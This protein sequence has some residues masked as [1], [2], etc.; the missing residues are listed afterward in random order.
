MIKK[1]IKAWL[2]YAGISWLMYGISVGVLESFETMIENKKAGN[3]L[4]LITKETT[5]EPAIVG[6]F[7]NFKKAFKLLEE[8]EE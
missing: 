5:V 2:A 8:N 3:G 4:K 1:F 7:K 6:A